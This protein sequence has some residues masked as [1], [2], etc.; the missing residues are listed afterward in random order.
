MSVAYTEDDFWRMY[1][2]RNGI[3]TKESAEQYATRETFVAFDALEQIFSSES[4]ITCKYCK[5]K[6]ITYAF[7]AFLVLVPVPVE[8]VGKLAGI[9]ILV[10][11]ARWVSYWVMGSHNVSATSAASSASYAHCL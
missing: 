5:S 11:I 7:V 2:E 3:D 4:I 8:A 10:T 9:A 6:K 1:R